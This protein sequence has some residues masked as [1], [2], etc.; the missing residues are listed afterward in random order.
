MTKQAFGVMVRRR[1]L[2]LKWGI[3]LCVGDEVI[4]IALGLWLYPAGTP[5]DW[6]TW[7]LG[8]LIILPGVIVILAPWLLSERWR[9]RCPACRA[10][11][12]PQL[13]LVL[14]TDR[15]PE[16]QEVV[17]EPRQA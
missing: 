1:W 13:R 7:V 14:Q 16:C 2:L 9:L 10:D 17:F 4:A 5:Q 6:F 12:G 8:V 11:F 15:C 3:A